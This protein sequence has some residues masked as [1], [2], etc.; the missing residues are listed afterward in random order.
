M[1]YPISKLI[2]PSI[3]KLWVKKIEGIE[4]IPYDKTFIVA[5]NH[6]SYFDVFL[7]PSIIVPKLNKRM[8]A[9]VNGHYWSNFLTKFF[10]DLWQCIPVYVKKEPNAKR[11]N[12]LALEKALNYIKQGHILMIFPEGRRSDGK[13][14][15]GHTGIARLALNAK[16]PVLPCGIVGANK[17]LPKGKTFPRFTR[18][19]VKIGK[20][21]HFYKYYNKKH[22]KKILE[23]ST[24]SVMNEIGK[25]IGQKYNY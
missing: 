17:I 14:L 4:N 22:T 20:L 12:K 23:E 21:L 7:V 5:T 19:E 16:V 10:L 18:C 9:L 15:K 2:I 13:L 24:R 3:Y 8:H 25:L 11:K 1:V 6:S